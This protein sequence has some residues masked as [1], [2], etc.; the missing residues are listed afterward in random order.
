MFFFLLFL[1]P[2]PR[3]PHYSDKYTPFAVQS[4]ANSNGGRGYRKKE[5]GREKTKGITGGEDR[6]RGK[7]RADNDVRGV[8]LTLLV[9]M[10]LHQ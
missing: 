7:S 10:Y 5:Q 3:D 1:F 2:S 6:N 9:Y 8:S 4:G